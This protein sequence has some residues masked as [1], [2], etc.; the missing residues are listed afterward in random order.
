VSGG[1]LGPAAGRWASLPVADGA[2]RVILADVDGVITRGEGQPLELDILEQLAQINSQAQS[3]PSVPAIALC[4]GRQAP[5]VE[6][7]AQA[8]GTFLPC[9][10]EH[11]AGLFFP[12]AFRYEFNPR[13]GRDYAV[14]LAR[15]RAAIDGPLLATGRA[16]VQPGKE[17]SMSLYPLG[18]TTV[19]ELAQA[20]EEVVAA[21][22]LDFTVATN[23]LGV[24]LRRVGIDKGVGARR[25]G[26]ILTIPLRAMVGVGDS[27]PDLSY[28]QLTGFSAAPANATPAVVHAVDYVARASFGRGLLEI[29]KLV[30]DGNRKKTLTVR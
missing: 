9:V 5:Y 2:R 14:H 23:V 27:D 16:F 15:L 25:I 7:M 26:E 11:G 12:E 17:A 6:L 19:E 28:L 22:A 4:T 18:G 29:L 21:Q 13:L 20:A 10:F 8:T 1:D 30:E 24:E 3:D